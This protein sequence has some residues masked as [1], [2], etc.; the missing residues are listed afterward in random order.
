MAGT[1]EKTKMT[2]VLR[3]EELRN[4]AGGLGG[5][6]SLQQDMA[7]IRMLD[8]AVKSEDPLWGTFFLAAGSA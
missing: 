5:G 8:L 4:V 6:R 3:D 2:R 1:N 7:S